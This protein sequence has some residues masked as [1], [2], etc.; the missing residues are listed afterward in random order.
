MRAGVLCDGF[1]HHLCAVVGTELD[2]VNQRQGVHTVD[3]GVDETGQYRS[4]LKLD[5]LG[6]RADMCRRRLALT[7]PSQTVP[8]ERH[9]RVM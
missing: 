1:K 8:L 7:Q 3:M 2:A 9:C 5:D 6:R 4:T